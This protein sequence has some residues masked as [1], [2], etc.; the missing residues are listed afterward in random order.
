MGLPDGVADAN[1]GH[2][3]HLTSADPGSTLPADIGWCPDNGRISDSWPD[4]GQS[5]D[6][7]SGQ[8]CAIIVA[9][10]WPRSC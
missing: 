6:T 1:P 5:P 7:R 9:R 4:P 8:L 10:P 2:Q 3:R